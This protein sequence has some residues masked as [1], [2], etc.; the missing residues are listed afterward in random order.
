MIIYIFHASIHPHPSRNAKQME[1][2]MEEVKS[3]IET[4]AHML[5]QH[6]PPTT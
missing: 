5:Y 1:F 2:Y 3:T 4:D 6:L